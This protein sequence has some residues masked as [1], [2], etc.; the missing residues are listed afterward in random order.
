MRY[1]G[2]SLIASLALIT[3]VYGIAAQS[4]P[5]P[6]L[7]R[8]RCK[9]PVTIE[10]PVVIGPYPIQVVVTNIDYETA[11]ID[12]ITE[13]GTFLHVT[14]ASAYELDRL[15]IGDKVE[16]CITAALHGEADV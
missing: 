14:Q 15:Q 12:F 7:S 10:E 6:V 4:S 8:E 1:F 2:M 16:L 3:P 9:Q 11:T 13:V 5:S